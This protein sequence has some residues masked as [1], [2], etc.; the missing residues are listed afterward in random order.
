MSVHTGAVKQVLR[1][2]SI[3]VSASGKGDLQEVSAE[4]AKRARNTLYPN[5][6]TPV[7]PGTPL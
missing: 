1:A 7:N 5:S 3:E 2:Y 4:R 6:P